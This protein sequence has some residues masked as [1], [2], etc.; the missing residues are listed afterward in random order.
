MFKKLKFK[1]TT[2]L[3][4]SLLQ[5][6]MVYGQPVTIDKSQLNHGIINVSYQSPQNK[7][8]KVMIAKGTAKHTYDLNLN[9]QYPLQ[10]GDGEYKVSVLENASGNKY[11]VVESK[12]VNLQQSNSNSVYLQSIQMINWDNDMQAIKTAKKLT[13]NAHTDKEKATII[14]N[15]ITSKIKYDHHKAATVAAGYIPSVDG[16][17]NSSLGICYDYSVLY[18]AMMRSVGVPTK[19][20][21]GYNK[22]IKDYHAWNEVYLQESDQWVTIDTTYDA[23]SVQVGTAVSMV[24]NINH[25]TTQKQF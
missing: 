20:V 24:K 8:T 17:L 16:T 10:L 2:I 7:T 21:M 3:A 14:Y 18:A 9:G 19:L 11:K 6:T 23:P 25:Y 15:Y 5:V 13:K 1:L 22:D 12:T 4:V